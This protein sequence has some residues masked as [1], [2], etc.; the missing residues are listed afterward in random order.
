MKEKDHLANVNVLGKDTFYEFIRELDK[1]KVIR[2]KSNTFIYSICTSQIFK[3]YLEKEL[4]NYELSFVNMHSQINFTI[5]YKEKEYFIRN[6][7]F[8]NGCDC[9]GVLNGC[10]F[11]FDFAKAKKMLDHTVAWSLLVAVSFYI[12]YDFTGEICEWCDKLAAEAKLLNL[13]KGHVKVQHL[14]KIKLSFLSES[15]LFSAIKNNLSTVCYKKIYGTNNHI[16]KENETNNLKT[17]QT[18]IIKEQ[19]KG[20]NWTDA[21]IFEFLAKEGISIFMAKENFK[22]LDYEQKEK[23][24]EYFG[25]VDTPVLKHKHEFEIQGIEH[26][27]LIAFYVHINKAMEGFLSLFNKNYYKNTKY[28]QFMELTMHLFKMLIKN[29]KK[30]ENCMVFTLKLN[31][32]FYIKNTKE[33]DVNLLHILDKMLKIY[34]KFKFE[35]KFFPIIFLEDGD[36]CILYSTEC[37]L[38]DCDFVIENILKDIDIMINV[39]KKDA[40][41]IIKELSINI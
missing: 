6:D 40:K 27:M 9:D 10:S 4:I 29:I 14:Q 34:V 35:E 13:E 20:K 21:K 41:R 28:I 22:T 2:I 33:I 37:S 24:E 17:S 11:M 5:T 25:T 15:N 32:Y 38:K 31:A 26:F 30:S 39:S 3:C 8:E 16:Y 12:E 7:T 36:K 23:I 18:Q 19:V 1:T